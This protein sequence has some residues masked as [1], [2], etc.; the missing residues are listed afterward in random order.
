[1]RPPTSAVEHF[2]SREVRA[3][4][5]GGQPQPE[6]RVVTTAFLRFDGVDALIAEEGLAAAADA[7]DEL[8]T[9]V[10][11]VADEFEVCFLQSDVDADG[12]K[13]TLT[14]GAP[15]MVGDDEERMLLALRQ[16]AS[17]PLRLSLRIGVN[18]GSVFCGDVG[19]P[20]RRAYTIMGDAVNLAARLMAHAPPGQVYATP[21]VIERSATRFALTP[22]AAFTVKGKREPVEAWAVGAPLGSRATE[23]VAVRFPLVGRDAE[24]AALEEALGRRAHGRR[25][26]RRDRGRAGHRQDPAGRGAAG[27]AR[28]A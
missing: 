16:I 28:A 7:I 26:A 6:H 4:V 14:A 5:A 22:M 27:R 19:A 12:G 20:F 13:I 2:L 9:H 17:R 18:R 8:V 11:A 23:G 10:Q 15:R 21:G 25:P 1:M 3:H 24:L